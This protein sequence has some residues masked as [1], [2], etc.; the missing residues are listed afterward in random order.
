MTNSSEARVT[1][2]LDQ[3]SGDD[4]GDGY[5]VS[6]C[7]VPDVITVL[8]ESA[9]RWIRKHSRGGRPE[10]MYPPKWGYWSP[11]LQGDSGKALHA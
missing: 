5:P 1:K 4:G 6:R 9:I 10:L 8:H 11:P 2:T 3:P 7:T